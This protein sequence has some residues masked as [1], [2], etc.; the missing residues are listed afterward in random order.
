VDFNGVREGVRAEGGGED[1]GVVGLDMD[2]RVRL[3]C[4]VELR[5]D[6]RGRLDINPGIP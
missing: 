2:A 3:N 5:R 6:R 4:Q 1:E